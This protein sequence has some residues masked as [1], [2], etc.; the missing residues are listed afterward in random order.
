M[1]DQWW[2]DVPV[3]SARLSALVHFQKTMGLSMSWLLSFCFVSRLNIWI[4]LPERRARMLL[5]GFMTAAS[6]L[7]GRRVTAAWFCR[8]MRETWVGSTETIHLSDSIV[9]RPCLMDASGMPNCWSCGKIQ[10]GIVSL[11]LIN[12]GERPKTRE[13]DLFDEPTV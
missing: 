12:C 8:S 3:T 7:M 10:R 6:A 4:I 1:A 2:T 9:V 13:K 5:A 11:H